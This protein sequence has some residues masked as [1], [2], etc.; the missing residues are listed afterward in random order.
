MQ[1]TTTQPR[2]TAITQSKIAAITQTDQ[3]VFNKSTLAIALAGLGG[4][5]ILAGIV[6]LVSAIILLSTA[7]MPSLSSTILTNA[8]FDMTIGALVIASSRALARGKILAVWLYGGS[9]LLDSLY[10]LISGYPLH[11][12]F[13][14]LGALVIWQILKFKKG[15]K[16]S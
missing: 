15:W 5:T 9:I 12:I 4:V 14:G 2:I 6:S 1:H 16:V 13:I 7:S 10:S 11:Y 8:V 3:S